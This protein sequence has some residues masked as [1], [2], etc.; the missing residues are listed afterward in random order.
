MQ[1]PEVSLTS[2]LMADFAVKTRHPKWEKLLPKKFII[3]AMEKNPTLLKLKVKIETTDTVET[4][5]ITSLVD[6]GA[7][8]EFID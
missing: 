2:T 4:K 5:S 7:T 6:C 1:K 8:G 3:A